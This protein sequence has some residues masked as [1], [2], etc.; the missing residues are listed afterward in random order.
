MAESIT[1]LLLYFCSVD[2]AFIASIPIRDC[3][4]LAKDFRVSATD[5]EQTN[6]W[7]NSYEMQMSS[8]KL[9]VVYQMYKTGILA[10]GYR[11]K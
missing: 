1:A 10:A 3:P 2:N 4:L 5:R 6:V 7:Y 11:P 9:F 8:R